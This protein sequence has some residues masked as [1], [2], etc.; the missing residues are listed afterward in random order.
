MYCWEN[1]F[2]IMTLNEEID[3][4]RKAQQGDQAALG[5]LWD[6]LTPKLFGYLVN[7]VRNREMAEDVL[8]ATWL[9]AIEALPKFQIRGV[10]FSSW[11]FAIAKNE[12]RQSW[13]KSNREDEQL[14]AEPGNSVNRN[15]N[16]DASLLIEQILNELSENDHELIRLRYIADLTVNDIAKV[17]NIN[18]IAVR[19]RLHRAIN[20]ARRIIASNIHE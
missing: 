1:Q 14:Q 7:V 17:L 5:I 16:L 15:D 19:V 12:C 20:R 4:V 8:Q 10:K 11:L 18:S 9:R 13:R 3:L 6:N 2:R